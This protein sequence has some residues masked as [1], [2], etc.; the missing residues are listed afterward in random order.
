MLR[1]DLL[2]KNGKVNAVTD[3]DGGT[4]TYKGQ[5]QYYEC[6]SVVGASYKFK[7]TE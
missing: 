3:D 6:M 5:R 2:H 4:S 1:S 7:K